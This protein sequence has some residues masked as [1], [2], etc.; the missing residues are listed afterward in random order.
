MPGRSD[1]LH[2]RIGACRRVRG[3][4]PEHDSEAP[5]CGR[6]GGLATLATVVGSELAT[7][8]TYD[9]GVPPSRQTSPFVKPATSHTSTKTAIP[10]DG[11]AP[12]RRFDGVGAISGG[13]GNSR[14]LIDYPDAQRSAILEY[15][16]KPD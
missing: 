8:A 3:L 11:A 13:G 7:A 2:G 15:L 10:V 6:R 12:G 5:V 14:Y 4:L 16:F 1:Y 9:P